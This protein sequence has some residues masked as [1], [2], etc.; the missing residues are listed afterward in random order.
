MVGFS[1][2]A[3]FVGRYSLLY[4]QDIQKCAIVGSGG[5]STILSS[6]DV[7]YFYAIGGKEQQLRKDSARI[8]HEEAEK[9]AI[10]ITLKEYP[11]VGHDFTPQIQSDIIKFFKQ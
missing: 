4:P 11:G 7:E 6:N 2:G 3:Q 10:K 8:F 1:A 5:N 9:N